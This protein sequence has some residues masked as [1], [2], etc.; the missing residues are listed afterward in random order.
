MT[1]TKVRNNS[2]PVVKI[3]KNCGEYINYT[4]DL[5]P[6]NHILEYIFC[7]ESC[8]KEFNTPTEIRMVY[9]PIGE[10]LIEEENDF[11]Y[12][13][14]KPK[15]MKGYNLNQLTVEGEITDWD[16]FNKA[17]FPMTVINN[18]KIKYI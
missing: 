8:K 4:K 3:C 2:L 10:D 9:N 16:W 7:D 1:T 17:I 5:L 12:I 13:Q 18:V 15:R 14:G 6:E 11:V